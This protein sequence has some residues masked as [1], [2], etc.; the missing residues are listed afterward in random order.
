VVMKLSFT[1][2]VSSLTIVKSLE[3]IM[4]I[5]PL[6]IKVLTSTFELQQ[7]QNAI[8][9]TDNVPQYLYEVVIAP[10]ANNDVKTPMTIV[11]DFINNSTNRA[12][13]KSQI[14]TWNSASSIPYYELR[15]TKPKVK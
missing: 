10:D 6:R 1:S 13:L 12:S 3:R 2:I 4:R 7:M 9:A 8:D 14:P 5:S 11:E 15:V